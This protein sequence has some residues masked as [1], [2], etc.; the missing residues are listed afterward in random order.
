[1]TQSDSSDSSTSSESFSGT[2]EK[3]KKAGSMKESDSKKKAGYQGDDLDNASVSSWNFDLGPLDGDEQEKTVQLRNILVPNSAHTPRSYSAHS[4]HTHSYSGNSGMDDELSFSQEEEDDFLEASRAIDSMTQRAS[5]NVDMSKSDSKHKKKG[6]SAR[7]KKEPS[8][9]AKAVASARNKK[10][11][12]NDRAN[13]VEASAPKKKES[14]DGA[15]EIDSSSAHS[16][17]ESNDRANAIVEKRIAARNLRLEKVR[18]RID[19]EKEEELQYKRDIEERKK[20]MTNSD[21]A[22]RERAY[23]WY[24]RCG[25]LSRK[26]MKK[27]LA[28]WQQEEEDDFLEASR[29]MQ[30]ITQRALK[31]VDIKSDANRKKQEASARKKKESNDRVNAD[32]ASARK[33]KESNDRANAV[34]E[35]RRAARNARLE[36]VRQRIAREKEEELQRK[37]DIEERKKQLTMTDEARRERAYEWYLRCGML[38]RKEMKKRLSTMAGISDKDIDLLPW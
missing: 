8:D 4:A 22:R 7:K 15:N 19:R 9:R 12:S 38:S 30:S 20:L 10:K 16:K 29:A 25:M 32:E 26:E 33:K 18:Q 3:T 14:N 24:L 37:R 11:E 5:E 35:Q 1:M 21:E 2:K 27:R 34:V 28:L 36:K 23:E 6:S 31:N 13:A 17:K